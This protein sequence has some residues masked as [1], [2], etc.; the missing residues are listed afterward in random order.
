[1]FSRRA[2]LVMQTPPNLFSSCL[3]G[4]EASRLLTAAQVREIFGGISDMTLWRWLED[5]D[6]PFPRPLYVRRRRF[7]R[8]DEILQFIRVRSNSAT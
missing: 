1:M 7:W 4:R 8:E 3:E 2:D 6:V 5:D